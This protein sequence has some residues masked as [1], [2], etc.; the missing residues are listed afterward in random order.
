MSQLIDQGGF[1]CIF[2]PGFNCKGKASEKTKKIVTKLQVNNYTAHNEIFIGSIIKKIPNYYLFFLPVTFSCPISLATLNKK[3]VDKCRILSRDD[4]NYLL[5]ELPYVKHISFGKLFSDSLRSNKHLFLTFI[6]TFQYV[7]T[8]IE[9]LINYNIVHYDLKEEN[10][11]YSTKYENPILIDFGISIPID[12]V[13]SNNLEKYFYVYGPDYYIWPLEVHAINF[14]VNVNDKLLLS[15]IED[16]VET[17]VSHNSGLRI[18]SDDF[19]YEYKM[20]CIEFLKK[21]QNIKKDTVI[22]E[23]LQYYKTWDLYSL[24]ILYLKF[25]YTLFQDGFFESKFIINFSQLLLTNISPD[26]SKRLSIA[27]TLQKY[28][29]IFFINEKPE[30]YLTLITNLNYDT[31]SN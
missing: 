2:Y 3:Y 30:N 21:Y 18:F 6:E 26:P 28:K 7:A 12:K 17:Y 8:S 19:K 15:D 11:L 14:L 22:K 31:T 4:P 1:G 24:S 16:L 27:D 13:N 10:I 9:H 5:L 25:F 20:M 29:D 23:L